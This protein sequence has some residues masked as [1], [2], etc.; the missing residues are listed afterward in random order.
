MIRI[1]LQG[2]N[3]ADVAIVGAGPG[4]AAA[5]CHLARAGF[6]VV[7]L[8]QRRFPRDKVCGDF[9]GPA[10]IAEIEHLGLLSHPVLRDANPIRR[11]ALYLDGAK[12]IAQSV[13]QFPGLRDHGLCLP[14]VALDQVVLSQAVTSGARLLEEARVTGYRVE[15]G[16]VAV[17]YQNGSGQ[18]QIKA[19]LLIGA[20]GSS[21]LISRLLR[22]GSTHAIAITNRL[23]QLRGNVS[24]RCKS[25]PDHQAPPTPE[26]AA[27][28]SSNESKLQSLRPV[29]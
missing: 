24:R 22:G 6:R 26:T 29:L 14:R 11:A 23:L 1:R 9:V 16:R 18:H 7:L 3:D 4:G 15:P 17:T 8:D 27:L 21:S 25:V 10:A 19:R 12:L 13:P 2:S 20:D 5:A 28:H